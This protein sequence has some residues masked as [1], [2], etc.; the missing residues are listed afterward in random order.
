MDRPDSQAAST[1][2]P[3]LDRLGP[4]RS[5]Q[6]ASHARATPCPCP[7]LDRPPRV[8]SIASSSGGSLWLALDQPVTVAVAVAP[9]EKSSEDDDGNEGPA[10]CSHARP[11]RCSSADPN[12]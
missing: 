7:S 4:L 12:R 2:P 1:A 3:V 8:F 10:S 9:T 11:K 6:P 5:G